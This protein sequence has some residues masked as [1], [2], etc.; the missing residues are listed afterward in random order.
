MQARVAS[1]P[2]DG[3][4]ELGSPRGQVSLP[5]S[6]FTFRTEPPALW[7]GE[8]W[9]SEGRR[10]QSHQVSL[11]EVVCMWMASRRPPLLTERGRCP[12]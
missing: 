2:L 1:G 4:L 11:L 9:A 12:Q 3:R 10:L 6:A 7:C 5:S 8:S